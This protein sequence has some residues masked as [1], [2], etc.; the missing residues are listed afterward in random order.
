LS[1]RLQAESV[2]ARSGFAEGVGADRVGGH[3]GQETLFLL[4]VAPA[5]QGVVD[6]RVLHVDDDAGG[7][8]HARQFFD[9]QDRF[10]ELGSA[11]AVLLWD[12]DA[13]QA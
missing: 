1:T 12:F 5:Q 4:F 13:H 10:E 2:G 11:A 9:G 8:V 7:R 3:P 6:Q